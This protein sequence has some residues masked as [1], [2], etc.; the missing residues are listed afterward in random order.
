MKLN[1]LTIIKVIENSENIT[2]NTVHLYDFIE[3]YVTFNFLLF[4]PLI[5][6]YGKISVK[7]WEISAKPQ[8]FYSWV[9]EGCYFRIKIIFVRSFKPNLT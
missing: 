4:V 1:N 2:L 9:E 3:I 5:I 7:I 6:I 8:Q